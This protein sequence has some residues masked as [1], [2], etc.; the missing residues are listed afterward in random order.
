[1]NMVWYNNKYKEKKGTN[2]QKTI[3]EIE[4]EAER[5]GRQKRQNARTR[6]K[7]PQFIQRKSQRSTPPKPL[8]KWTEKSTTTIIG[9]WNFL[10]TSSFDTSSLFSSSPKSKQ[11]QWDKQQQ[12][13]A[14]KKTQHQSI[15]ITNR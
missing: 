10:F 5:G 2:P 9:I 11:T 13:R 7:Q 3:I 1:M 4:V 8:R 12:V 14:H 6:S 15:K